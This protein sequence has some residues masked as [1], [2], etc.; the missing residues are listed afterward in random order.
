MDEPERRGSYL[1]ALA[2]DQ[3]DPTLLAWFAEHGLCRVAIEGDAEG[4]IAEI[5]APPVI[6]LGKHSADVRACPNPDTLSY[7]EKKL[8]AMSLDDYH[9]FLLRWLSRAIDAGTCTCFICQK[10]ISNDTPEAPW[11]GIFID[12][13]LVCWLVMHFDCKRYLAR[14]FKG[15]HPFELMPLPPEPY[16]VSHD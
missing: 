2:A 12:K 3:T 1:S 6:L 8:A 14:D 9:I 7:P 13:E 10:P 16:D 11:D 15:Y 5:V 4:E